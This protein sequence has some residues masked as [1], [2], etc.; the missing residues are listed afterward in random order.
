MQPDVQDL[1]FFYPEGHQAHHEYGHPERPERVEV[2]WQALDQKGWWAPYPKVSPVDL[3]LESLQTVHTRRYLVLLQTACKGGAHL[4]LDTYTT[5]ASWQVA[6]DAAGGA[7]AVASAVWRGHAHRGF[8]LTRPPGHHA[9]ASQ[10]MGFCLVNNVAV[11]AEYLIQVEG[12][13]RLAIVDLDLHH[14]NGTQEIFWQRGDVLYISTHQA[15]FYPGS[16]SVEETG[17]GAGRGATAN[18]PLPAGAGDQA[19]NEIM[20]AFILPLLGRY[21]PEMVLVSF[22]FD[23]HWRDPLGS[24]LLSADCYRGL[25]ERLAKF[26]DEGAHGKIALFLEGGYDLD[27]AAVCGQAAVAGLLGLSFEDRLGPAPFSETRYWTV[28]ARRAKEIWNL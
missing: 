21:Q 18:F 12:V 13:K 11:A 8:A 6:L 14:G 7:V 16:G 22:G 9:T 15:P 23:T 25:I 10:G 17:A 28:M 3:T 4:D 24:L 5:P 1:I 27:A 2:L 20:D 26:C 19:F